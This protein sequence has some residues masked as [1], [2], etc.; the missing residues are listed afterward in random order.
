MFG[1]AALTAVNR[2][3][4]IG[5]RKVLG[6]SIGS[7][8]NLLSKEF[9]IL[10]GVSF[11]IAAP[12]AYYFVSQWLKGYA[13][14]IEIPW[15]VFVLAGIAAMVVAFFTVGIQSFRAAMINPVKSLKSE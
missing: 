15:L 9:L 4:E 3:K 10:V 11:S 2:T 5:I 14:R 13:Y 6:A 7:V 12:V 1:L 8:I